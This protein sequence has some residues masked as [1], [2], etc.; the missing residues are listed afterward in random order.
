MDEIHRSWSF[1]TKKPLQLNSV[2]EPTRL[3]Y[4]LAPL[5]KGCTGE[6]LI[7]SGLLVE[8]KIHSADSRPQFLS[9]FR[10]PSFPLNPGLGNYQKENL[11]LRD[12]C[13]SIMILFGLQLEN[14]VRLCPLHASLYQRQSKIKSCRPEDAQ[15]PFNRDHPN[16]SAQV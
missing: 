12:L 13:N 7:L 15:K 4:V 1:A 9:L 14:N 11:H 8:S 16:H 3:V 2:P 5:R 10:F 6:C